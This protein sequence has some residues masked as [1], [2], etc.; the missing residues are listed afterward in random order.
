MVA[1][2]DLLPHI[3]GKSGASR[4]WPDL[5]SGRSLVGT[6]CPMTYPRRIRLSLVTVML[7]SDV[8]S[9]QWLSHAGVISSSPDSR[10][11]PAM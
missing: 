4:A 3:L 6:R 10:V 5:T 9:S 8:T 1:A 7:L 11:P 2:L